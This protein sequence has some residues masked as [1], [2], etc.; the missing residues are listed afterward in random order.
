MASLSGSSSGSRGGRRNLGLPRPRAGEAN[1][2]RGGRARANEEEM[3]RVQNERATVDLELDS[4][5]QAVH[6]G[7]NIQQPHDANE[8][9][10][11]EEHVN[12]HTANNPAEPVR[13]RSAQWIGNIPRLNIMARTLLLAPRNF[14][15]TAVSSQRQSELETVRNIKRIPTS[16]LAWDNLRHNGKTVLLNFVSSA[17]NSDQ[18]YLD[19][20]GGALINTELLRQKMNQFIVF[21]FDDGRDDANTEQWKLDLRE[22]DD[23]Q[24]SQDE[25]VRREAA[26][27]VGARGA[28][29][30]AVANLVHAPG[31]GGR[32][33]QIDAIGDRVL[34]QSGRVVARRRE[35]GVIPQV[36]QPARVPAA[37]SPSVVVSNI[38]RNHP[39]NPASDDPFLQA[40]LAMHGGSASG[41]SRPSNDQ[42]PIRPLPDVKVVAETRS[43]QMQT[44]IKQYEFAE[45]HAVFADQAMRQ[46]VLDSLR[47]QILGSTEPTCAICQM[48]LT[49]QVYGTARMACCGGTLHTN[50]LLRIPDNRK[51]PFCRHERE[52]D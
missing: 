50:C 13:R 52:F 20:S 26:A 16:S 41:T 35:E 39:G 24:D 19:A 46:Q 21:S 30:N 4:D 27:G 9:P 22:I 14:E 28:V 3:M 29:D 47:D 1:Q 49:G 42:T 34:S 15:A 31:V 33:L 5:N 32:S 10:R 17:L 51:C 8:D 2:A 18:A 12:P 43:I 45:K 40:L 36:Q 7:D 6:N 44:Q 11:P 38:A 48:S 37:I 23:L 25:A